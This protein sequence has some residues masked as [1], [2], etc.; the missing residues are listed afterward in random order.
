VLTSIPN[1]HIIRVSKQSEVLDVKKTAEQR[2]KIEEIKNDA[3]RA[4]E[5]LIDL[6]N[7]LEEIG[8]TKEAEAL[9]KIIVKL[10]VWQ[11]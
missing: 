4:K 10:E 6:L 11:H 8:A 3:N 5:R 2:E 7:Q 1:G 9:D